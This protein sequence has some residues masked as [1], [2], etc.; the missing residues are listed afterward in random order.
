M[1]GSGQCW[2]VPSD[3]TGT[4][5]KQHYLPCPPGPGVPPGPCMTTC[6]AMNSGAPYL[7]KPQSV[8][9]Q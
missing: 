4:S 5:D 1:P 7:D 6:Q 9:C 2:V 8:N 3:C